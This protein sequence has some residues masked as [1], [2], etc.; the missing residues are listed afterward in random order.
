[1]NDLWRYLCITYGVRYYEKR[2]DRML[3]RAKK[4]QKREIQGQ[5]NMKQCSLY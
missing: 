1:M 3:A 2:I 5:G 4:K